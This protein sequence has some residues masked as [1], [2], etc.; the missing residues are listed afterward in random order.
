MREKGRIIMNSSLD[1]HARYGV[2]MNQRCHS[3]ISQN[4]MLTLSLF[5]LKNKSINLS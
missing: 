1:V 4:R 2:G 3:T 5:H